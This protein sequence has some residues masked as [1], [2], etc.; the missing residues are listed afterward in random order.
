MSQPSEYDLIIT[1]KTVGGENFIEFTRIFD[2]KSMPMGGH[3]DEGKIS[4]LKSQLPLMLED[5][6]ECIR[7]K[8][9]NLPNERASRAADLL[10]LAGLDLAATLVGGSDF[11][12]GMIN[13][14][15]PI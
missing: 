11:V 9:G 6:K 13:F 10:E 4:K 14:M 2:G 7:V 3:L 1:I 15:K 12:R 8:G 5:F